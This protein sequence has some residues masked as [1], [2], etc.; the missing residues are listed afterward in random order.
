MHDQLKSGKFKTKSEEENEQTAQA[1]QNVA[2]VEQ[3]VSVMG[4]DMVEIRA[5]KN[6]CFFISY[7]IVDSK[8]FVYFITICILLNVG[9][10]AFDKYPMPAWEEKLIEVSNMIFCVVF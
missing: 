1:Y 8:P 3:A 10:L 2:I 7:K 6:K 4:T 9:F 5:A